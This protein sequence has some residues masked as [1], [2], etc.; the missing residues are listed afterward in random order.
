MKCKN[1]GEDFNGNFCPKCGVKFQEQTLAEQQSE[2]DEQFLTQPNEQSINQ[3][4]PTLITQLVNIP[5]DQSPTKSKRKWLYV[6]FAILGVAIIAVIIFFIFYCDHEWRE[7]TCIE[8]K[9][10]TKCGKTEGEALGHDWVEANCINPKSCSVCG[11]TEGQ[12][13]GHQE[14]SWKTSSTN[15]INATVTSKKYCTVCDAELDTQTVALKKLHN[16][17]QFLFSP[18]QFVKRLNNMLDTIVD[19]NIFAASG[20]YGDEFVCGL[21]SLSGGKK[22]GALLF[23]DNGSNKNPITKSM[24]N[25]PCFCHILGTVNDADDGAQVLL[26]LIMTCDPSLSFSESKSVASDAIKN[27]S[28]TKNNIT[29]LVTFVDEGVIIGASIN[30]D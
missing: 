12:P 19:N 14:G 6:L 8:P 24:K 28:V 29:Y 2:N 15:L 21:L 23:A 22:A 26:A 11:K 1:C 25:K 4:Q 18:E 16:D 5:Q 9:T 17:E 20:A 3:T 30:V 10:C 13:L 27:S 7:A